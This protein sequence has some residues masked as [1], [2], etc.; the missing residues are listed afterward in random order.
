VGPGFVLV[1]SGGANIVL[2]CETEYPNK[3]AE[4]SD[5]DPASSAPNNPIGG[6]LENR[7]SGLLGLENNVSGLLGLENNVPGLLDLENNVSGLL[8]LENNVSGLLDLENNFS[9]LLDVENNVSGLLDLENR[10]SDPLGLENRDSELFGLTPNTPNPDESEGFGANWNGV[11]L[12]AGEGEK[13]GSAEDGLEKRGAGLGEKV[14]STED[15][16]E[17]SGTAVAN[18][19]PEPNT[20]MGCEK[21]EL[22]IDPAPNN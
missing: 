21:V 3:G 17:K 14:G 1:T 20:E 4:L 9:G 2:D 22:V 6:T 13:V 11:S 16:L 19:D 8:G 5:F 10:V 12:V 18:P 15:D 7:V